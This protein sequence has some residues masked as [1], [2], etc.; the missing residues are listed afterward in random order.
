MGDPAGATFSVAAI[1]D[2][3][4]AFQWYLDASPVSGGTNSSLTVTNVG[5]A[6]IGDY[7]AIIANAFG[8]ATSQTASLSVTIPDID[9]ADQTVVFGGTANFA[10]TLPGAGYTFQWRLDGGDIGGATGSELELIGALLSDT[11]EY[12]VVVSLGG[13]SLTS[14]VATLDVTIPPVDPAA[15]VT[16]VGDTVDFSVTL[17]GTGYTYQ[18]KKAGVN[19]G[20]ALCARQYCGRCLGR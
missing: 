3:P 6:E 9:P 11:G 17:P 15:Q 8:S 12:A 1:G 16:L 10:M 2:A 5:A 13:V 19:L 4:L 18:W 7:G 20:G 14:E